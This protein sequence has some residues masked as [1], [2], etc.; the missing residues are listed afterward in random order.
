MT[1]SQLD[2]LDDYRQ[3]FCDAAY[4]APYVRSVCERHGMRPCRSIESRVPGTCPVFIVDER[5]VVKLY[6]RL[7][8]GGAS[9]EVERAA[10]EIVAQDPA[11]PVPRL[12]AHGSLYE[13]G[14]AWH[15]PYLIFEYVPGISLSQTRHA[16]SFEHKLA[17]AHEIGQVVRRLHA[18][19]LPDAGPLRATWDA[20][21]G[22][23][24]QSRR[25]C[26]GHL[27]TRNALPA[28]L[29][30]QIERYLPPFSVLLDR[31]RPLC[32]VHAD[33]T[34]D[35]VLGRAGPDDAWHML[36]L[37]D[38]GDALAGDPAYDLVA[39]HIDLFGCDKRL[40]CAY[41]HGYDAAHGAATPGADFA[42]NAM[43][44]TLLHQFNAE[45]L[46]AVMQ[47]EEAARCDTLAELEA[48]LWDVSAT[49][50]TH[51]AAQ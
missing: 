17:L 39:L 51:H 11:I 8:G 41:L 20:F 40:L 37:I 4:W 32:L 26:A 34:A 31:T 14:N 25:E 46:E 10:N 33:L 48:W 7:F 30:D 6:G 19:P 43:A 24:E 2:T 49:T 16:V 50:D 18:L 28:R 38:F 13:T 9:F 47:H 5:W 35:H 42:R 23:L 29:V 21:A 15:W 45:I 22:A 44:M 3:R 12:I 27:R 36:T 1:R